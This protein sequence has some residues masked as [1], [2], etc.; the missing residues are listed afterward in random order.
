[1]TIVA[2]LRRTGIRYA[3]LL[4]GDAPEPVER[5]GKSLGFDEARGGMTASAKLEWIRSRDDSGSASLFVGDGLNDAPTLA[6]AG[7]S[8]SFAEAPQ[9]ALLA[10][11]FVILGKSLAPLAAARRIARRSRRLLAQNVVWALAYNLLCVP[12]AAFGLVPPWAAA[13]GMSVSSL[14]VVANAMRLARPAA[15]EAVSGDRVTGPCS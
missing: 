1:M 7:T 4:S 9:L 6:A 13:L 10:S 2:D 5:L 14:V 11:D 15:G 3:A 12:L 8:V